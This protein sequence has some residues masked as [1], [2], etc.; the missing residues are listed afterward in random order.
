MLKFQKASQEMQ[1]AQAK[2]ISKMQVSHPDDFQVLFSK[3][4]TIQN[5]MFHKVMT[6]LNTLLVKDKTSVAYL[7]EVQTKDLKETKAKIKALYTGDIKFEGSIEELTKKVQRNVLNIL[8]LDLK[9]AL[10]KSHLKSL[11]NRKTLEQQ[12]QMGLVQGF[13]KEKN[14]KYILNASYQNQELMVNDNNLTATILPFLLMATQAGT[15]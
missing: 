14:K 11:P 8:D 4:K 3:L 5:E 15:F 7:L 1:E 2:L 10:D 13:I 12:I 6:A 9:V